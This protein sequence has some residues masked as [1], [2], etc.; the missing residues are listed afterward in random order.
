MFGVFFV[1]LEKTTLKVKETTMF[2]FEN[3]TKQ[4]YVAPFARFNMYYSITHWVE[5]VSY[6]VC[7]L[8]MSLFIC[9][10]TN[11]KIRFCIPI[12]IAHNTH[13]ITHEEVLSQASSRGKLSSGFDPFSVLLFSSFSL[14]C[15]LNMHTR[16]YPICQWAQKLCY[17]Y[18]MLITES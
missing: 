6:V 3:C 16:L 18:A 15:C 5:V 14:F 11:A 8:N 1:I 2:L 9:S 4:L 7:L 13:R 12:Y 10:F 17:K